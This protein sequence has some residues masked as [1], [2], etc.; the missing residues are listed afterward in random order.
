MRKEKSAALKDFLL[1]LKV[2]FKAVAKTFWKRKNGKFRIVLC[3]ILLLFLR[4]QLCK[5]RKKYVFA[6]IQ[7]DYNHIGRQFN[8]NQKDWRC[9]R[10]LSVIEPSDDTYVRGGTYSNSNFG[11]EA[12]LLLKCESKINSSEFSRK[13]LMR[14]QL[15]QMPE[16]LCLALYH[17]S[18]VISF[19]ENSITFS[20]LNIRNWE[21]KTVTWDHLTDAKIVDKLAYTLPKKIE[22]GWLLFS[23]LQKFVAQDLTLNF[24]V[25]GARELSM[26]FESKESK[27]NNPSLFLSSCPKSLKVKQI[28]T[29]EEIKVP[30]LDEL[31]PSSVQV[32]SHAT[33]A[34]LPEEFGKNI[35][36]GLDRTNIG[37]R[38]TNPVFHGNSILVRY[39]DAHQCSPGIKHGKIRSSLLLETDSAF[40]SWKVAERVN[41]RPNFHSKCYQGIEDPRSFNSSHFLGSIQDYLHSEYGGCCVQRQAFISKEKIVLLN[42]LVST[43]TDE[44]NWVHFQDNQ[45][46]YKLFDKE[47]HTVIIKC[48]TKCKIISVVSW[49]TLFEHQYEELS[50]EQFR[51]GTNWVRMPNSQTML[52][53]I[54]HSSSRIFSDKMGKSSVQ[55]SS[56]YVWWDESTNIFEISIAFRHTKQFEPDVDKGRVEFATGL[57][58]SLKARNILQVSFGSGDCHALIAEVNIVSLYSKLD[59]I[60]VLKGVKDDSEMQCGNALRKLQKTCPE[61]PNKWSTYEP[62]PILN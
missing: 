11:N 9:I 27:K 34:F 48:V 41:I 15:T 42:S 5:Y 32:I 13:I 1:P 52:V 3:L 25:E 62:I 7:E 60:T 8:Q 12:G 54:V 19:N 51:S 29:S 18:N 2:V 55:Y 31:Y 46:I 16:H 33:T 17:A 43:S 21:E 59:R 14:F 24:V 38:T 49:K 56:H 20:N 4:F 50:L 61:L 53:S 23:G 30:L 37:F 45:I 6:T 57:K 26:K 28:Q 44:K 22:S 47:K 10:N 35:L 58:Y 39:T 36:N 40:S